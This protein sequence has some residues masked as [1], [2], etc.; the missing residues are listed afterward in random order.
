MENISDI[1]TTGHG[2]MDAGLAMVSVAAAWLAAK[3]DWWKAQSKPL[4]IAVAVS[5]FLLVAVTLSLITAPF[6]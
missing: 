3:V 4:R 6:T 2:Y 5:I 1:V